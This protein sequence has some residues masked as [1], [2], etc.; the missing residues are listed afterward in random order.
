MPKHQTLHK[1][2]KP[3]VNKL[4]SHPLTKKIVIGPYENCRHHYKPGTI[5]IQSATNNGFKLN[6]YDGS[7][8]YCLFLYFVKGVTNDE[9]KNVEEYIKNKWG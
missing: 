2:I 7:G 3:Q 4:K 5:K 9:K 1:E 8:V 6:G